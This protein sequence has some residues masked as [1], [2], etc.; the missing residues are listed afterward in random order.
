MTASHFSISG[1][2]MMPQAQHA[3]SQGRTK[4]AP[5]H[6]CPILGPKAFGPVVTS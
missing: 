3:I 1:F 5:N 6:Q 4:T 2:W